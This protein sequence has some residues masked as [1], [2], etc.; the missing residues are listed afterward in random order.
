MDQVTSILNTI[1]SDP[2]YIIIAIA[3]LVLIFFG[4]I[5]KLFKL[6]LIIVLCTI[7]YLAFIYFTKGPEEAASEVDKIGNTIESIPATV[8]E[9]IDSFQTP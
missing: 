4:V 8:K 5:K 7:S 9:K 3:F 6:T 2:L 1:I